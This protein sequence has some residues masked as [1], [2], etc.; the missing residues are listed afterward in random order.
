MSILETF[1]SSDGRIS[2]VKAFIAGH[3]ICLLSIYAPNQFEPE[4]YKYVI[5][6][7]TELQNNFAVIIGADMNATLNPVLD[8]SS[9]IHQHLHNLTTTAFQGL[10]SDFS[11]IDLYRKINSSYRKYSF[12]SNRHK[13]YS[14]IDYLLSSPTVISR[15]DDVNILPNSLSDHATIF[16]ELTL[17]DAPGRATRWRFNTTLLKNKEFCEHLRSELNHFLS[18]N[19]G[20]VEDPRLLLR[21]QRLY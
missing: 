9:Q 11:L 6:L 3:K 19:A 14:R 10:V 7:L 18:V 8:R 2:Y 4:F 21:N 12:Y 13:T 17:R 5:E 20:S 15:V 1:G 16:A